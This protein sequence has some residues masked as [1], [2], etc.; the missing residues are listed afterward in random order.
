MTVDPEP[1]HPGKK[2]LDSSRGIEKIPQVPRIDYQRKHYPRIL[3]N[4]MTS[5]EQKL[6]FNPKR[7][8]VII[9]LY[10]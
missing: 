6:F 4:P 10:L 2:T 8:N 1:H 9:L 7:S 3:G 5:E